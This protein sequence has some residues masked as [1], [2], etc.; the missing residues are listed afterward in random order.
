MDDL[1]LYGKND[2]E[3]ESLLGIVHRFSSDVGME[4]RF[5]KCASLRIEAG[6]RKVSTGIE[7]PNGD[8][9]NDLDENGYKYL[10][11]LQEADLKCKEMKEIV[12]NEYLRRVKAVARSN[13][14][15]KNLITSIN[16]W[17]VTVVRYSAAV[18]D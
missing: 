16:V 4:F 18:I 6:V 2:S 7:L 3:L 1:K 13:L 14:Y 5:Q 8:M 17:A 12:S 11:V 9:I 10:G 15:A